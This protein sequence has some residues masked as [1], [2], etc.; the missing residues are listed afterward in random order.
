[1]PTVVLLGHVNAQVAP[2]RNMRSLS[3]GLAEEDASSCLAPG[4]FK[5]AGALLVATQVH[6]DVCALLWC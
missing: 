4:L 2:S 3:R 5:A 6:V 1:M